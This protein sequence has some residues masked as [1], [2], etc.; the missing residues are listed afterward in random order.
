MI[1]KIVV[2]LTV[3]L[4]FSAVAQEA[5]SSPYSFY[6]LGISRDKGTME[7]RAMGGMS[8]LADSIHLNFQNPAFYSNI[9]LTTFTVAGNLNITNFESGKDTEDARRVTLDYLAVG[10]PMGKFSAGFGLMPYT[11]VGYKITRPG[12]EADPVERRYNGTGGINK[13]FAGGAYE[14][15]KNFSV[16][17]EFAYYFGKIETTSLYRDLE[18]QLGTRELNNS[19]ASGIGFTFGAN[20]MT[21][22]GDKYHLMAS[23]TFAPEHN[24]ALGNDRNIGTVAFYVN[25]SY[26]VTASEDIDVADTDIKMPTKYSFGVGF[27]EEKKWM[28]GT[29]VTFRQS[30][31]QANRLLD[32]TEAEFQNAIKWSIGGYYIPDYDSFTSYFNKVVYRAG[33]RF[34]DTGLVLNGESITERA[35]TFGIGLPLGGTFSNINISA[36]IGKRGTTY[37]GLVHESY[38]NI[39]IALSLNDRWFVKRKY[40]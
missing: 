4:G 37:A 13:V 39:G 14:V 27:G 18:V 30:D 19:V 31:R 5:T 6:G 21:K 24:V 28:V 35:V 8:V 29:E 34:E 20:Y 40:D 2:S 36:E 23:A 10:L 25:G 15:T 12:T 33:Y 7:N 9:K 32:I 17:A 3:L 11:S 16:G 26:N 1:K 22:I 38:T